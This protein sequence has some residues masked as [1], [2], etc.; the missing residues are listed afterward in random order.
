MSDADQIP[1]NFLGLPEATS[2][3][4]QARVVVVPIGFEAT[5]SYGPGTREGPEAILA[6][7]RQ[8][9]TYQSDLDVDLVEAPIHTAAP[10][11]PDLSSPGAMTD[12]IRRVAARLVA[13]G[14]WVLGL[15]GEHAV[16]L[17]LVRAAAE[18]HG[19]LGILQIDAHADLRSEFEGTPY[20]HA[21]VMRRCV[22]D[23]HRTV[24]VGIRN[25]CREEVEFARRQNLPIF[26]GRQCAAS[27]D[28]IDAAVDALRGPVYLT[29]DVDGLDP[30]VIRTTGTP[31]PGGLGWWQTMQLLETLFARHEVVGADVVELSA[32]GDRASD[33]AAARLAARIAALALYAKR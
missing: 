33:F 9:E 17:G 25:A 6:A 19:T 23:G 22:E 21:S 1:L 24:H 16:T 10:V 2:G 32:G 13:D 26:W 15:G 28:W 7:S 20:S 31:E 29:V 12:R 5:T 11:V 14:K 8:V 18:K 27:D 3:Y 30:S 4:A